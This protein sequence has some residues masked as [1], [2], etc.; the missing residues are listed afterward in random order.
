MATPID[1][2]KVVP[3]V[4]GGGTGIGWGL[5][6]EFLKRGSPKVL[7]SGRRESVLKEAAE[8]YPDQIFYLANDVS[9]DSDREAL[10]QWVTTNH[11]DCNALVNNAGVIRM[12]PPALDTAAAWSD[13]SKEIDV[14]LAGPVHLCSL[15]TSWFLSKK[16]ECYVV[17]VTSAA[18]FVPLVVDPV[19]SATKAALH[20]YSVAMRYSLEGSNVRMIEIV[21]PMVKTAMNPQGEDCDVYCAA[22]MDSIQAGTDEVCINSAEEARSSDRLSALKKMGELGMFLK[23]PTFMAVATKD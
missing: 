21:P 8:K 22:T 4:T 3:L 15:F 14:N 12:I 18:V 7:I 5:V 1:L 17:N 2:S 6:L 11:P 10:F 23:V 13:K 20:T 16:D 19:Y 9:S